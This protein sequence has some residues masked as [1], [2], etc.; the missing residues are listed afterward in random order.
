MIAESHIVQ[1]IDDPRLRDEFQE[2]TVGRA[3][4]DSLVNM[5]GGAAG[6]YASQYVGQWLSKYGTSLVGKAISKG[7]S[8]AASTGA[9][10]GSK[11][12]YNALDAASEAMAIQL[13]GKW[14]FIQTLWF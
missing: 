10:A 14:V 4:C 13:I 2:A 7:A 1:T 12:G 3:I 8:T 5:V 6:G 9:K 11:A